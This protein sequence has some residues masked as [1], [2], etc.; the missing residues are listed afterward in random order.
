MYLIFPYHNRDTLFTM[1]R[2]LCCFTI[3][4]F[5]LVHQLLPTFVLILHVTSTSSTMAGVLQGF[6]PSFIVIPLV[7][8]HP[9]SD[10]PLFGLPKIPNNSSLLSL[11]TTGAFHSF[12]YHMLLMGFYI[13]IK[14]FPTSKFLAIGSQNNK[15]VHL[16]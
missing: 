16:K 1:L 15:Q 4:F 6:S 3:T 11:L 12:L 13:P 8:P 9:H 14:A 10:N 7:Y 2:I 5:L